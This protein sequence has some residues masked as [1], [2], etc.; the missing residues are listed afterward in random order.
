[1]HTRF[2]LLLL[3]SN[4]NG[5]KPTSKIKIINYYSFFLKYIEIFEKHR[6]K[7][8]KKHLYIF[9]RRK[10]IVLLFLHSPRKCY[11]LNDDDENIEFSIYR[12][13]L[14]LPVYIDSAI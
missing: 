8:K 6:K 5:I 2:L 13:T 9:L 12:E 11:C 10:K 3:L 4:L 1:M 7:L 14:L